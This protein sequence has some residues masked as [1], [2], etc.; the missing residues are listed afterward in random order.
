MLFYNDVLFGAFKNAYGNETLVGHSHYV[1]KEESKSRQKLDHIRKKV[2]YITISSFNPVL[3]E[4]SIWGGFSK[5]FMASL[6]KPKNSVNPIFKLLFLGMTMKAWVNYSRKINEKMN[7]A[8]ENDHDYIS[9]GSDAEDYTDRDSNEDYSDCSDTVSNEIE[10]DDEDL[11]NVDDDEDDEEEEE[12][13]EDDEYEDDDEDEVIDED[14]DDELS[15]DNNNRFLNSRHTLDKRSIPIIETEE[16]KKDEDEIDKMSE[17]KSESISRRINSMESFRVSA[18]PKAYDEKYR[19]PVL[20]SVIQTDPD[21]ENLEATM[22]G[23]NIRLETTQGE[24]KSNIF[25]LNEAN[26]FKGLN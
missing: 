24:D 6:R 22:L 11:S 7:A 4:V 16:D 21:E 3:Q 14:D 1:Q 25:Q 8:E 20:L 18:D 9:S 13:E 10:D 23:P 17:M 2:N 12:E 15:F 19:P 26:T 5:D